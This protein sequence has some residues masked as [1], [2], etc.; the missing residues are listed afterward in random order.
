MINRETTKKSANIIKN[1][2][3]SGDN[4]KYFDFCGIFNL[5]FKPLIAIKAPA[6]G[7]EIGLNNK[8]DWNNYISIFLDIIDKLSKLN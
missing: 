6:I 4:T 3:L 7:I 2:F 8:H 1:T 5:P